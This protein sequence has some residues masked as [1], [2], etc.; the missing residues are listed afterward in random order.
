MPNPKPRA[1][2]VKD[3]WNA[4]IVAA[5]KCVVRLAAEADGHLDRGLS[6]SGLLHAAK[7]IEE[8][9]RAKS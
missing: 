5:V 7:K 8:L 1:R 6:E 4:A 3:A 2:I 9:K